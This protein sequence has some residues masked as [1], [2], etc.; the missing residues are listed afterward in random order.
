MQRH[1]GLWCELSEWTLPKSGPQ[2]VADTCS[3]EQSRVWCT[4]L[5]K[6]KQKCSS[7]KSPLKPIELR[8]AINYYNEAKYNWCHCTLVK[9]LLGIFLLMLAHLHFNPHS[10]LAFLT[11]TMSSLF[12]LLGTFLAKRLCFSPWLMVYISKSAISIHTKRNTKIANDLSRIPCNYHKNFK[13]KNWSHMPFFLNSNCGRCNT[14][15]T[16]SPR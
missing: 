9:T 16:F 4:A 2:S 13:C 5:E 7:E 10:I 3:P 8:V 15:C 14:L 11:P 12:S 1:W 6:Y